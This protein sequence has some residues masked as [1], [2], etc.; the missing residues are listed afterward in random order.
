MEKLYD[1]KRTGKIFSI[2]HMIH[3]GLIGAICEK[4]KYAS[5]QTL[6]KIQ[7]F[8]TDFPTFPIDFVLQKMTEDILKL[9]T[10]EKLKKLIYKHQF[11][12]NH[13]QH[14][15][16]GFKKFCNYNIRKLRCNECYKRNNSNKRQHS[17]DT[18]EGNK[19]PKFNIPEAEDPME[20]MELN[21]QKL[22]KGKKKI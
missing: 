12:I 9:N 18:D 22:N 5:E 10:R 11:L 4:G 21:P 20:E 6:G 8:K 19:K 16:I 17:P 1:Q 13:H 2:Y 7:N 14:L 15:Q 3:I